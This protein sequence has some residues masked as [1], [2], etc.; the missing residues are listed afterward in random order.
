M[1]LVERLPP[2]ACMGCSIIMLLLPLLLFSP[3]N[4]NPS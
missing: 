3:L 4:Y 2:A 1:D